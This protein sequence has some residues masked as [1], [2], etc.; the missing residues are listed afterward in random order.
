MSQVRFSG[1]YRGGIVEVMAGWDRPMNEYYLTVFD[2]FHDVVWSTL[3]VCLE[4]NALANTKAIQHQ[5]DTM[6]ITAPAEFWERVAQKTGN[7]VH[8]Y[9]KGQ[10]LVAN[11]EGS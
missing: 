5:L 1:N 7:V 8:V 6:E 2:E 4:D 3:D 10:W 11:H 9:A